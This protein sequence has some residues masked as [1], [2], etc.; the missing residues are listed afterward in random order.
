M[1]SKEA[2]IVAVAITLIFMLFSA[3]LIMKANE[4]KE[5]SQNLTAYFSNVKLNSYEVKFL[6]WLIENDEASL[7]SFK[8]NLKSI[9]WISPTSSYITKGG[10]FVGRVSN[11]VLELAR[12][13]NVLVV[14]L[15]ANEGFSK[16]IAH[17]FLTNLKVRDEVLSN[18]TSFV[19]NG[20]YDGIN[21]DFEGVDPSDREALTEFMRLLSI[22]L[23]EH[24]K[25]VSIDVPAKTYDSKEG[26]SG[27][28]DYKALGNYCDYVVLMVYDYHWSGS[29]P[30]PISPLDWLRGVLSYTTSVMPKEKIVVG[31]P[32]YGYD[33]SGGRGS[34]VT[35][36]EAINLAMSTNAKV[37]FD[38]NSGEYY[39][40]AQGHE[41]WFQGAKST[42]LRLNII[43]HNYNITN[44][45]AWRL[46]AE[47]PKTWEVIQR[48]R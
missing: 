20:N 47:D 34:G 15:V 12:A 28:Y 30:G 3:L 13:N 48:E 43:V 24:S 38:D 1:T 4:R 19:V 9:T 14:P 17:E 37:Y 29:S 27:A 21:I 26:W 10:V 25:I 8:N 2:L 16:D 32:F 6:G 18:L 39:F 45:A 46:G 42:E 23:H 31:I 36:S 22:K 11:S 41:V 35:F 40:K 44:I 5:I 33:W 7:S